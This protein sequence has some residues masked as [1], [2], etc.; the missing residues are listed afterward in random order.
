M[1]SSIYH[2][3]RLPHV[4]VIFD[5]NRNSNLIV[6]LAMVDMGSQIGILIKAYL[7]KNRHISSNKIEPILGTCSLKGATSQIFNPFVGKTLLSMRL[8]VY[9]YVLEESEL[10]T[11]LLGLNFLIPKCAEISLG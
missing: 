7:D 6:D 11:P 5:Q 4:P 10:D 2:T 8:P 9:F 3:H 1:T